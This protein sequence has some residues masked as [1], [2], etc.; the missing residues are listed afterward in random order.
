MSFFDWSRSHSST[1]PAS[2]TA[3]ALGTIGQEILETISRL[4]G[5][6]SLGHLKDETGLSYAVL[7]QELKQ[8]NRA[9]LIESSFS[10]A[11]GEENP[12]L[13]YRRH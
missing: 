7:E 4:G 11:E 3:L 10:F 1:S 6:V 13:V 5:E 9:S 2:Q 8:L 12:F